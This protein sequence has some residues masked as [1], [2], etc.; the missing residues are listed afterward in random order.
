MKGEVRGRYS[1][2][3]KLIILSYLLLNMGVLGVRSLCL[4]TRERESLILDSTSI[5]TGVSAFLLNFNCFRNASFDPFF[6]CVLKNWLISF[7]LITL[8]FLWSS[9]I[10]WENR[11]NQYC[12]SWSFSCSSA[13]TLLS[14]IDRH[15]LVDRVGCWCLLRRVELIVILYLF[16]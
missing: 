5:L 14:M 8:Y 15:Y 7:C 6:L 12:C 10:N 16:H 11:Y 4:K 3:V 13:K 9:S 1:D 2:M